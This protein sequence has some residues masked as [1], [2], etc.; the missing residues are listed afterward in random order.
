MK[1]IYL[2]ALAFFLATTV[3]SQQK[4]EFGIVVSG[5]NFAMPFQKTTTEPYYYGQ[6]I[7]TTIESQDAGSL[8]SVGVKGSLRLGG[9]FRVSAEL[10]YRMSTSKSSFT[11][12]NAPVGAD[13][14][15]NFSRQTQ[16]VTESSIA[17]PIKLYAS[18]KKNG[19]TSVALGAGL[20]RRVGGEL[21]GWYDS[22]S[23]E[24]PNND[25]HYRYPD[26]DLGL[27]DF[28][29]ALLLSAG[30]YHRL[31]KRTALGLEF[32]YERR[33]DQERYSSGYPS[34]IDFL[35]DCLCYGFLYLDT[36]SVRNFS[37]TLSHS[38]SR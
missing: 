1:N 25:Y 20:S 4:S 34:N 22:Q 31:D 3:F 13:P 37:L 9:Y 19:R 32:Y 24:Y 10:L 8:F 35:V 21:K 16:T 30:L 29:P 6:R 5:G 33:S 15:A 18:F 36:P 23:A 38:F 12:A 27:R 17:I 26:L 2:S 11:Y 14:L 28:K 7:A